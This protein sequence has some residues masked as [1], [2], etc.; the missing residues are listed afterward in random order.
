MYNRSST[1]QVQDISI[2]Q[3]TDE[4]LALQAGAGSQAS[5]EQLISK[6]TPR[7]LNFLRKRLPTQQDAE[8]VVQET[9]IKAFQYIR[10]YNTGDTGSKFSTWLYTIASRLAISHYRSRRWKMSVV[11]DSINRK[12]IAV[13]DKNEENILKEEHSQNLWTVAQSLKKEQYEALWLHYGEE[14]SV[15]E[16]ADV[17]KRSQV[18]VRVLLHRARSKLTGLVVSPDTG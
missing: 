7:L 9:F 12:S 13:S 15:K 14:M 10:N 11:T 5:F 18:N 4:E 6:Y 1:K 16:I 17:M 2:G 3:Q 8:D